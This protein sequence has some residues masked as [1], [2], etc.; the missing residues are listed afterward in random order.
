[1]NTKEEQA[2][3]DDQDIAAITNGEG[4]L[5]YLENELHDLLHEDVLMFDFFQDA[6]SDGMWYWDLIETDNEWMSPKFWKT[7]GIDPTTKQHL[8]SEWQDLI[9]EEDLEVAR[10]NLK[11]HLANPDFPYDQIVRYYHRDGSTVW[12]RCRGI[13]IYN[14][15]GQAIRLLGSHTDL[16]P[17]MEKQQAL[18]ASQHKAEHL[19]RYVN[20]L[21][22]ELNVTKSHLGFV[23]RRLSECQPEDDFG[24]LNPNLFVITVNTLI[25]SAHAI[26]AKLI[27]LRIDISSRNAIEQVAE[28]S[29][30]TLNVLKAVAPSY[31]FTRINE[32][33]ICG[34]GIKISVE[35]AAEMVEN[36]NRQLYSVK[37]LTVKPQLDV[38]YKVINP[39]GEE[40]SDFAHCCELLLR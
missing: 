10:R 30:K 3:K 23:E 32:N 33:L 19:E 29:T 6:A 14:S 39:L 18:I 5:H 31:C 13:A 28:I 7:L 1:M 40:C 21:E 12:I 26:G 9:Y 34:V 22:H 17:V 2:Q 8:A 38:T 27:T 11:L 24:F 16:T 25:R 35:A 15:V 4:L 37:W 36:I 20:D